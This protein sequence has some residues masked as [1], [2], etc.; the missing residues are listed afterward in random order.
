V[1]RSLIPQYLAASAI[2]MGPLFARKI[3]QVGHS[4]GIAGETGYHLALAGL[5]LVILANLASLL[6]SMNSSSG[7]VA[8]SRLVVEI[9]AIALGLGAYLLGIFL[10]YRDIPFARAVTGWASRLL[11]AFLPLAIPVA[12]MLPFISS[13][14]PISTLYGIPLLWVLPHELSLSIGVVW[15]A[16]SVWVVTQD[17]RSE[18][19]AAAVGKASEA[20]PLG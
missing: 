3:R 6:L 16:L 12:F 18:R 1:V 2:L 5:L 20:P 9:A 19:F 17:E 13:L 8:S 7:H 11:L 15:L 10:L 14:W 4:G